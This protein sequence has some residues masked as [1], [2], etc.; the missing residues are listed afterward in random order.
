[1][2]VTVF[3]VPIAVISSSDPLTGHAVL[4]V[5]FENGSQFGNSYSWDFGNGET[6]VTG[7]VNETVES[8][9]TG[10]GNYI[11]TLTASNGICE[12]TDSL[13]VM[14][15][16]YNPPSVHVPNV[17]TPDGDGTNDYFFIDVVN[18]VSVDL[19]I[20]NR[21]GNHI[22]DLKDLTDKWDGML[23]GN[24]ASEGTYFYRYVV[25]GIDGSTLAGQGFVELIR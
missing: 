16:P 11:V 14:V 6:A 10:I 8:D 21:W 22:T 19:V 15:V 7:F 17:F 25:T 20:L 18:G 13:L 24:E 5:G 12:S 3:P 4:T 1:V 9:Y 2:T 23:N